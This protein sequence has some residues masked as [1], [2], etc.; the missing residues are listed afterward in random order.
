MRQDRVQ[1]R[2]KMRLAHSH[3]DALFLSGRPACMNETV[4]H[5]R[6]WS[7][8]NPEDD[9]ED[10]HVAPAT[11]YEHLMYPNRGSSM[12]SHRGGSVTAKMLAVRSWEYPVLCCRLH[13]AEMQT[14]KCA[15]LLC[16]LVL[17][18]ITEC[19]ALQHSIVLR[20]RGC[21]Q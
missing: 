21:A 7:I 9:R 4:W 16:V 15:E 10:H 3:G 5:V 1:F 2:T 19:V 17:D 14:S 8:R 11:R 13:D 6:V 20:H 18:A 12:K